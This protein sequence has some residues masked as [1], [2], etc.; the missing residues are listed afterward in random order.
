MH[1][2]MDILSVKGGY[3]LAPTHAMPAD[4]PAENVIAFMEAAKNENPK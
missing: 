1:R 4:I 2:V 3:I